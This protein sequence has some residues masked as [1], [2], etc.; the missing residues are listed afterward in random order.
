[1]RIVVDF[2][3]GILE[4]GYRLALAGIHWGYRKEWFR[5]HRLPV[6]VI[7]VGNLTWGGTGK[8]PLVMHLARLL[9]SKGRRVAVLTRGYGGDEASL[10]IERLEPIPVL[11]HPD[12]VATGD[13]AV[14]ELGADVLLMDDGYQQWRVRKDLEILMVD[15]AAPFGNGHLIP[16]G[17]LREPVREAARAGVIVVKD[18][19]IPPEARKLLERQLRVHN[20]K[21]PILFMRYRPSALWR[22]NSGEPVPLESLRGRKVSTLAG[23]GQP[24]SFEAAIAAQGGK[25]VLRYRF[26][27]H[28][29]YTA[30]ELIRILN[31]CRRHEVG[32]LVTTA[33]DAVRLPKLLLQ[34]VGQDLRGMD[35]LVLEI[36]PFFEPNES[37]LHHRIDSVLAGARR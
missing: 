2:L 26:R 13:R 24:S 27:D 22:W 16:R 19:G 9:E 10:L 6:P 29:P 37:E 25:V 14:R 33:K 1:M 34:S 15:G 32:T 3:T 28:H 31:R 20:A 4:G 30:G 23:I 17:T 36:T 12:R 35:V 8:T 21:A 18:S 11:V 5:V 7:S